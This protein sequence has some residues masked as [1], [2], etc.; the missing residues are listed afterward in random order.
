MLYS[1]VAGILGAIGGTIIAL[2]Y[3]LT[4]TIGSF[5]M[6]KGFIGAVTGV[7]HQF[8]ALFLEVIY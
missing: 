3:V 7:Y 5:Y 1:F 4:P 6:I 2:E 8:M